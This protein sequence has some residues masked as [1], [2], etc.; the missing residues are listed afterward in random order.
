MNSSGDPTASVL[1]SRSSSPGAR[2]SRSATSSGASPARRA[3][4]STNWLSITVQSRA[5]ATRRATSEPP[6]AYW[7]GMVMTG[8]GISRL[9]GLAQV[10]DV[11]QRQPTLGRDEDDQVARALHVVQHLDPL[12]GEGLGRERLVQEPL[13]LGLKAGDFDAVAL[14][15][16][17]LLLGDL[18]VDRLD[19]LGGRLQV[20]QEEGGDGGDAEL[21]AAGSRGGDRSEEHTSE[22]QSPCNLVCRLLL[23]KKKKIT[24]DA[25]R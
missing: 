14:C 13:L 15:L 24:A 5:A 18:V 2:S 1:A 17:L 19:H 12:L 23:E 11:E 22:L 21:P 20:A 25:V 10:A 9:Q 7:R 6:A 8:G 3:T 4:S 16:D